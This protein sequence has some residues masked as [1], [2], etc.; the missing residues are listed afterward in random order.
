MAHSYNID[1]F[2]CGCEFCA[3][4]PAA[5]RKF[6]PAQD[7]RLWHRPVAN[8]RHPLVL[9]RCFTFEKQNAFIC[10]HVHAPW[11][12]CY[13][14]K[15]PEGYDSDADDPDDKDN[16]VMSLSDFSGGT[17]IEHEVHRGVVLTLRRD[18]WRERFVGRVCGIHFGVL[19]DG[20]EHMYFEVEIVA[21]L[22]DDRGHKDCDTWDWAPYLWGPGGCLDHTIVAESTVLR[23]AYAYKRE[24]YDHVRVNMMCLR[25][26]VDQ[27]RAAPPGYLLIKGEFVKPRRTSRA[28]TTV[29]AKIVSGLFDRTT[30]PDE[31]FK[32]VVSY[33]GSLEPRRPWRKPTTRANWKRGDVLT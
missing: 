29:D 23:G 20:E 26:L 15:P 22:R 16:P 18:I 13:S 10:R 6:E 4:V 9:G 27:K 2:R 31:C 21:K 25:K 1:S 11:I 14:F 32:K 28:T 24:F 3:P 30:L 12:N 8:G 5:D 19:A 7:P 17:E 33:M